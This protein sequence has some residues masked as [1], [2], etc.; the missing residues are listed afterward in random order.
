MPREMPQPV[1]KKVQDYLDIA[2]T[3]AMIL[4]GPFLPFLRSHCGSHAFYK[5]WPTAVY[6]PLYAGFANAPEILH[7]FYPWLIALIF[8]GLTY[9][10]N[11]DS[12]YRG[13]PWLAGLFCR[14]E[15]TARF[16]EAL[17][18]LGAGYWLEGPTGNFLMIGA[19]GLFVTLRIDAMVVG[20]RERMIRDARIRGEQMSR[21]QRGEDVW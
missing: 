14:R 3:V 21:L 12:N 4:A 6:I 17:L 19:A 9:D 7:W 2:N 11:Q 8:R 16:L 10:R 13:W 5:L 1:E 20:A 18:L 15:R